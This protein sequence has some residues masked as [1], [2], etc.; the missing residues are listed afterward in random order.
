MAI[1]HDLIKHLF[2]YNP[3]T[4]ELAWAVYRASNAKRGDVI[5]STTKA[6]YI[7]VSINDKTYLAHRIIWL[8]MTGEWPSSVD[9]INHNP[10]D[11]RWENLRE[12]AHSD[13]MKNQKRN[14]TNTSG[15]AGVY[16]HK[17]AGKWM[18]SLKTKGKCNYLGV[19]TSVGDAVA[20]R[21]AAERQYGFHNNH[22][23]K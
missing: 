6:G 16:W 5:K 23:V 13:N 17:G 9:H 21:K 18:A 10:A 4:G 3:D 1:T 19:F 7:C 12:V 8:W 11:N 14:K 22:G 15:H 2:T 20:A